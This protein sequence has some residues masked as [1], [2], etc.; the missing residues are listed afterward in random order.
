[1][2]ATE[3]SY[4]HQRHPAAD[5][6]APPRLGVS[7][8]MEHTLLLSQVAAQV[9]DLVQRTVAGQWPAAELQSLLSYLEKAV[10]QHAPQ[11]PDG[12]TGRG[13]SAEL[14][15][16]HR[17]HARLRAGTEVLALTAAGHGTRSPSQLVVLARDLL[18]LLQQ[19]VA[20]EANLLPPPTF[21]T[22]GARVTTRVVGRVHRAVQEVR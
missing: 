14:T 2:S 19:H 17:S 10:L 20:A 21:G 11:E 6:P 22:G 13:P 3:V 12:M 15:A 18:C 5:A 9:N 7:P 16:L 1:M 4:P 8:A